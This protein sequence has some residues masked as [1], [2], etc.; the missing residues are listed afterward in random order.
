M[1][2]EQKWEVYFKNID[3]M[4]KQDVYSPVSDYVSKKKGHNENLTAL[5]LGAGYGNEVA[6]L[7]NNGYKVFAVDYHKS[8]ISNIKLNINKKVKD[9]SLHKNLTIIQSNFED[10]NWN[11][12]PKFDL[13]I[14]LNAI[15][16]LDK[17]NFNKVWRNINDKLKPNGSII[18]TL[19]GNK[20]KWWNNM[21]NMQLFTEK[22][23]RN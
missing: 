5:D 7:I 22:E 4:L 19:F 1:T 12:L 13:I 9:K 16:F 20:R 8:S 2:K 18:L 6:L 15:S 23:V 11:T 3:H 17:N 21:P 14:S 10:L